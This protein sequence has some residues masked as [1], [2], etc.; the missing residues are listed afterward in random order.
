M[1]LLSMSDLIDDWIPG[2]LNMIP[3]YMHDIGASIRYPYTPM[4]EATCKT[5][6]VKGLEL[7]GPYK[8]PK[9]AMN[10]VRP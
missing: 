4:L 7:V 5:I 6:N 10:P 3:A 9:I 8:V 2:P 1:C